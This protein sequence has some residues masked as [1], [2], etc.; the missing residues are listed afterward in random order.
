MT[1]NIELICFFMLLLGLSFPGKHM[2]GLSYILDFFPQAYVGSKLLWFRLLDYPQIVL[3]SLYY[4]YFDRSY[5][6]QMFLG[7]VCSVVSLFFCYLIM[8]ESPRFDYYKTRFNQVRDSIDY[9][10][11]LNGERERE[12]I[13]FDTEH[14]LRNRENLFRIYQRDPEIASDEENDAN[15]ALIPYVIE[16][17]TN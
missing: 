16:T 12:T 2:I 1:S 7:L 3:I 5:R 11:R 9:M 4:Q 6:I 15:R 10:R 14:M 8:P 13:I 17:R